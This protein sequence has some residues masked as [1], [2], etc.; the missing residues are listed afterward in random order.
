M[1]DLDQS[2]RRELADFLRKCRERITADEVGLP[3]GERR[4]APGLRREEVAVLAGVSPTWYTYLEQARDIQPSTQVLDSLARVLRLS[5]DERRYVHTLIHGHVSS[6]KPLDGGISADAYVQSLIKLHAD[7]PY[8]VYA[9]NHF[10]DLI[11]WNDA[12]TE[13]YDDWGELQ[14]DDRNMVHW[15]FTSP[16]ARVRLHDWEDEARDTLARWRAAMARWQGHAR[17][18]QLVR[19]LTGSSVEFARWWTQHDVLEHRSRARTFDHPRLGTRR[20]RILPVF[21]PETGSTGIVFHLP[22]EML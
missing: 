19:E 3:V 22:E 15:L 18:Q 10:A 1:S 20:M 7:S 12:A 8:P 6:P 4:R 9:S 21:S 11:A 17:P 2:R 16:R 13:W 5:E 14:P